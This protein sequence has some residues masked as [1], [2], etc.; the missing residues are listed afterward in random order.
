M[1]NA[2]KGKF[3]WQSKTGERKNTKIHWFLTKTALN[4]DLEQQYTSQQPPKYYTGQYM[5][6]KI[7]KLNQTNDTKDQ[8][9]LYFFLLTY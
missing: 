5:Y 8:Q 9:Q 4:N 2:G 6:Y 3:V 1:I 7:H